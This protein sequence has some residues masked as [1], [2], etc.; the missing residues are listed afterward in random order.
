MA[1]SFI[2]PATWLLQWQL[3]IIMAPLDRTGIL[4]D[5]MIERSVIWLKSDLFLV[6]FSSSRFKGFACHLFWSEVSELLPVGLWHGIDIPDCFK[7]IIMLQVEL[8][9]Y[10]SSEEAQYQG[11]RS[12]MARRLS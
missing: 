8:C 4:S 5:I 12:C 10:I 3:M 1:N 7:E 6:I 9:R 2:Q 11:N